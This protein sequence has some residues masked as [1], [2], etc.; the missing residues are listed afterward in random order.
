MGD[1][2]GRYTFEQRMMIDHLHTYSCLN[3]ETL[4][5][6]HVGQKSI[7]YQHCK[8][9]NILQMSDVRDQRFKDN[10]SAV[11]VLNCNIMMPSSLHGSL[12]RGTSH[13]KRSSF[14]FCDN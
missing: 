2:G 7:N 4:S 5:S 13:Q 6:W 9:T 12:G 14:W 10:S 1:D 8:N 3:Q 11:H